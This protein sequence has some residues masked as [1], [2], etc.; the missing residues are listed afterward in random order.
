MWKQIDG[1]EGIYLIN[2]DGT[3]F[4]STTL[5]ILRGNVNSWGYVVVGLVKRAYVKTINSID[6]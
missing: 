5:R 6:F 4:N 1:Y 2:S 3:I